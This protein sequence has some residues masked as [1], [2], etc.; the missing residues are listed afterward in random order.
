VAQAFSE[1]F[2]V[3]LKVNVITF[4]VPFHKNRISFVKSL[5]FE[6]LLSPFLITFIS[7]E[8]A[9]SVNSHVPFSLSFLSPIMISSLFL[10]MIL[11]VFV[12]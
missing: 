8:S 11:S 5:F 9:A 10:G 2:P 3:S 1:L 7:P 6:I 12:C 4:V